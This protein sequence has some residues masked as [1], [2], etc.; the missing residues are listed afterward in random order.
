[1]GRKTTSGDVGPR[2][3]REKKLGREDRPSFPS[4]VE[5]VGLDGTQL[6]PVPEKESTPHPLDEA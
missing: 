1:M 2:E 5:N 6:R 3:D 4:S